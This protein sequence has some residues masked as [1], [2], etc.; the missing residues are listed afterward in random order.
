[1][2]CKVAQNLL[3]ML[4][5]LF[6]LPITLT[7]G[8]EKIE[9]LSS[10]AEKGPEALLQ[11][12]EASKEKAP[13]IYSK[14]YV[15]ERIA[16]KD[17]KRAE[18]ETAKREFGRKLLVALEKTS[19]ELQA[20]KD[21]KERA[22]MAKVLLDLADWAG[23]PPGYGNAWLFYRLQSL[24]T[25]P[26]GYLIANLSFPEAEIKPLVDRLVDFPDDVKKNV[27]VLNLEAPEPIFKTAGKTADE[28]LRPL[29]VVWFKK[30]SEATK[31][32][33]RNSEESSF[34]T[35]KKGR[36]EL[37]DSL[38]FSIDDEIS[39]IR[40]FT[41]LNQWDIKFHRKLIIGLADQNIKELHSFLS[42]RQKVG[43][44]P[45]RIDYTEEE[46]AA[47]KTEKEKLESKGFKIISFE[48][49]YSSQ[50]EAAFAK[51]WE[52]FSMQYGAEDAGAFLVYESIF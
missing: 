2:K 4:A 34:P 15:D 24:A 29:E 3:L 52:P 7:G 43:K 22:R 39:N 50:R 35:G 37:P 27:R 16:P 14:W 19:L 21:S 1:M 6:F 23:E 30:L 51:A 25:V 47:I 31:W 44:F 20:Q 38:A 40:P 9:G 46:R 17:P 8:D 18:L 11:H 45:D 5:G 26:I 13:L 41:V 33:K 12:V 28:V 36:D 49:S 32:K 48:D 42:F 10:E